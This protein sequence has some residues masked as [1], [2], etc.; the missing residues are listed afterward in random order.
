[1]DSM[2][3]QLSWVPPP[4]SSQNGIITEYVVNVSVMDTGEQF[5]RRVVGPASSLTLPS[6]HPDYT[7]TYIVAA[8]TA[9]GTGPFSISSSIRMPE[10]GKSIFIFCGLTYMLM[11]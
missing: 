10:D 3:L 2:T 5:Q 7:Y 6:L 8:S 9:V 1:M 4:L 11:P